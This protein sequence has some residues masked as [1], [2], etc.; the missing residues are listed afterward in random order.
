MEKVGE[1]GE[2]Q[3]LWTCCE[4]HGRVEGRGSGIRCRWAL[5]S[6]GALWVLKVL[7]LDTLSRGY[8]NIEV[9]MKS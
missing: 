7:G 9:L 5:P 1:M 2:C 6:L 3:R 4:G 8:P